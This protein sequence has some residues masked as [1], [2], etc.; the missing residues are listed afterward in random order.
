M[1][2]TDTRS[3]LNRDRVVAVAAD[4]ADEHGLRAVTLSS[5]ARDVGVRTPSL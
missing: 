3:R 4:L 2:D 5:V 1:T